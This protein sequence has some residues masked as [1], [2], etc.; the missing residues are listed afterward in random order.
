MI[1]SV[2]H[3]VAFVCGPKSSRSF[4]ISGNYCTGT[5]TWHTSRYRTER[6]A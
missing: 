2:I 6:K 4:Q 5:G 3:D 1:I